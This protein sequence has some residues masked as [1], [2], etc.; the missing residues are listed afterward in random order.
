M[1]KYFNAKADTEI[2]VFGSAG[3]LY[4]FYVPQIM[5][6]EEVIK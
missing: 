5:W 3:N 1:I 4:E 6:R 2:I